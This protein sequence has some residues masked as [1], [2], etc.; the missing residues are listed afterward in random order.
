[1]KK[2]MSTLYGKLLGLAVAII[3]L[4]AGAIGYNTTHQSL[5]AFEPKL[6]DVLQAT[7]ITQIIDSNTNTWLANTFGPA[8]TTVASVGTPAYYTL[9][10]VTKVYLQQNFTATSSVPVIFNNPFATSSNA[11]IT[12][13]I[14]RVVC[15][16]TGAILGSNT[17]DLS[18]T[19]GAGGYGSSSPALILG[20]SVASL[21]QDN[22]LWTPLA[23]STQSLPYRILTGSMY[24]GNSPDGSSPFFWRNNEA[25]TYRIATGTPGNSFYTGTCEVEATKF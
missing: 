7:G 23:T 14:D 22:V 13:S 20:H 4:V 12:A 3:A 8:T 25:L 16:V 18:T 9:G 6:F 15:K 19:T 21:A 10:G 11:V 17:F 1:M 24:Q 2:L 5:G